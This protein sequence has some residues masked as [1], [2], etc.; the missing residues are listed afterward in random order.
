MNET[1]TYNSSIGNLIE[2]E[3]IGYSFNTPG[4]YIVFGVLLIIVLVLGFIQY[5]KYKKDAYRRN[6]IKQLEFIIQQNSSN[7]IYE[8]NALLKVTA[9]QLFERRKVASLVGEEWFRF[10]NSTMISGNSMAEKEFEKFTMALYNPKEQLG[11]E[12][13]NELKDFAILW[14]K[15][16]RINV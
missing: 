9:L 5:R 3:P 2:P 14:I 6:A 15:N 13:M 12:A 10:L 8:I 7:V 4:W 1:S 16:H 11:N